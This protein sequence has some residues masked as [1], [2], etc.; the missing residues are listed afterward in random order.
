[1]TKL[2]LKEKYFSIPLHPDT[3]KYL[4][5]KWEEKLYE[6][7]CLHFGKCP[8]PKILTKLLKILILMLRQINIWLIIYLNDMSIMGTIWLVGLLV[9]QG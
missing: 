7:L 9:I 1:M 4:R 2:D 5:L 3:K 6:F 8:A